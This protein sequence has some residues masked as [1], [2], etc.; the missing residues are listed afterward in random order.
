MSLS[1]LCGWV[2]CRRTDE[3]GTQSIWGIMPQS[4]VTFMDPLE[5]VENLAHVNGH[6]KT[7]RPYL[8]PTPSLALIHCCTS[9]SADVTVF[10][11]EL[12]AYKHGHTNKKQIASRLTNQNLLYSTRLL[13]PLLSHYVLSTMV[14]NDPKLFVQ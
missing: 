4:M 7:D 6:G 12:Q 1:K 10:M 13:S 8:S 5:Q 14:W 2:G 3:V 9:S 11:F